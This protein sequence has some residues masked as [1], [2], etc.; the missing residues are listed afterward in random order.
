MS[1]HPLSNYLGEVDGCSL[2]ESLLSGARTQVTVRRKVVDATYFSPAVPSTHTPAFAVGDGVRLV[3]PN[4]LPGLWQLAKDGP[5]PRRFVVLGGGKTAMDACVWL[6]QSGTPAEAITWVVPR[7]SWVVNRLSTQ[8]GPEFFHEAIGG[9]ADQM[10]AFAEACSI[11]DL[12][13]RLEA[14]GTL[15]V[16]INHA[17]ALKDAQKAHRDLESRATTGSGILKP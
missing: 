1:Y 8:N 3:A 12:Y 6:L 11:E 10:Q 2:F 16:P 13:L 5:L 15:H 17:Y 7:D 4:A 9:Q 14:C